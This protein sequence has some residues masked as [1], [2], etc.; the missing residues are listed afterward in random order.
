MKRTFA[1]FLSFL[2]AFAL[3]ACGDKN[4]SSDNSDGNA[5]AAGTIKIKLATIGP[6]TGTV[7]AEAEHILMDYIETASDG[8]IEVEYFPNSVLGGDLD[9]AEGLSNGSIQ[10]ATLGNSVLTSYSDNFGI[11]DMPFLFDS[12]DAALKALNEGEL[13]AILKESLSGTGIRFSDYWGF[14]GF[15]GLSNSVRPV[16]TPADM[17]GLKIRVMESPVYITSFTLLGA[18]PTP[19]SFSELFT[20]L[21]NKTVD[22]QDNDPSLTYTC[23]FYEVQPYYTDLEHVLAVTNMYMS[24]DWYNDLSDEYKTIID[25]ACKR[26]SDYCTEAGIQSYEDNLQLLADEGVEVTRLTAEN[27]KLFQEAVEPMY[28]E[29][30][31][32]W[33]QDIFDAARAYN[34]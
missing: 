20:A 21:Q 14:G 9:L 25:E 10:M 19:I 5:A 33:G 27:R 18:N 11:L 16:A 1:L 28:D 23:K 6:E 8:A 3:T 29:Y 34:N 15:R 26:F 32:R 7:Q 30:I 12:S 17:S 2:M 13:G 31:E 4:D 22:G 24:E